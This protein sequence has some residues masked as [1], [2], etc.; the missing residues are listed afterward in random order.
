M[1]NDHSGRAGHGAA[2]QAAVKPTTTAGKTYACPMHP[3]IRRSEPGSC[4]ICGMT[5]VEELA[6]KAAIPAAQSHTMTAI[7]RHGSGRHGRHDG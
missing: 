4:P 7:G 1:T 6:Q 5:L 2:P 3:E